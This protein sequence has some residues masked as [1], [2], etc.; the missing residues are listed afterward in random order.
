M[1]GLAGQPEGVKAAHRAAFQ[2][3][4][5][6][7]QA[8]GE[9]KSQ[10]DAATTASAAATTTETVNEYVTNITETSGLAV[11]NR[12]GATTYSTQQSDGGAMLILNASTAIAVTLT[13]GFT[14]PWSVVI[15]NLGAGT[16]TL[17]PAAGATI[18]YPLNVGATSRPVASGTSVTVA[19]DGSNFW[20]T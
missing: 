12:T 14:V 5:D 10:I 19:Y 4:V 2:G 11:S 13:T 3:L 1:T 16:A 7:N 15:L 17:T 18:S 6:L 8:V 9:L 20:S